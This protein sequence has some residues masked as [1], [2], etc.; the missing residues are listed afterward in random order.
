MGPRVQLRGL[1]RRPPAVAAR[2]PRPGARPGRGRCCSSATAGRRSRPT[3]D[4]SCS[5]TGSARC[6]PTASARSSS[7]STTRPSSSSRL[8]QPLLAPDRDEQ[9]GYV[10]NVVYSCGALVHADTLVLPYGIGDAAIG[11]ATRADARP[12]RRARPLAGALNPVRV[13]VL[14]PIAWRCPP[15]HYGPWE[16]FA[17]LLTEGLV[18]RGHDVTLFATGDSITAARLRSVVPT[19]WSEDATIEPKVAECLHISA[20]LRARRRVRRHP[21]RLRLPAAHLHAI[22]SRRPS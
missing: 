6:A 22:S 10:P 17:S 11:I 7:T 18:A 8:R 21:Q 3:P 12:A 16:L 2:R 13:A 14:A 4:G 1:L 20:G 15:R 9:D 19:G 5:P